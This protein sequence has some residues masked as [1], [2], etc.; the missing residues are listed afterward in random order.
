MERIE[1]QKSIEIV[2]MFL[3]KLEKLNEKER[4]TLICTIDI[5]NHPT[6]ITNH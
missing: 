4:A 3:D 2:H 5:L 1:N 6:F